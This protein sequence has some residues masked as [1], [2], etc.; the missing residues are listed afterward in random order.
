MRREEMAASIVSRSSCRRRPSSA[1]RRSLTSWPTPKYSVPPLAAGSG[2]AREGIRRAPE[3]GAE[4][5]RH[6]VHAAVRIEFDDKLPGALQE[7]LEDLAPPALDPIGE[8]RT[9]VAEEQRP[10]GEG[11]SCVCD[12][13]LPALRAL[14]HGRRRVA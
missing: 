3:S 2:T 10:G 9:A 5:R 11:R 4:R 13:A 7:E 6:E 1:P 8:L 14:G 12:S